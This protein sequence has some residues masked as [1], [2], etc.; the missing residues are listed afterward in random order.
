MRFSNFL[1]YIFTLLVVVVLI[2]SCQ[3]EFLCDYCGFSRIPPI[4]NAGNDTIIVIPADTAV[5]HGEKSSDADG[6]IIK[7]S[8]LQIEGPGQS[9]IANKDAATTRVK[10]L[11][12]GIYSFTLT[13]TD[14]SNL[15]SSDTVEV[16]VTDVN[17]PPVANAGPDRIAIL[18][19]D[20]LQLDGSASTD[21]ENNITTY[22]WRKLS[23]YS[24]TYIYFTERVQ[25]V[26][27][28]VSEDA[29]AFELTVTDAGGLSS[30]DTV[31]IRV[32]PA[33]FITAQMIDVGKN[34]VHRFYPTGASVGDQLIFAGGYE[35]DGFSS[36]VDIYDTRTNTHATAEL[37]VPRMYM[38][39]VTVGDKVY[40][41]GGISYNDK[42]VSRIDIY[43]SKTNTWTTDELSRARFFVSG[44]TTGNK[45]V[46]A[47][48]C[49][50]PQRE[51]CS[52]V[53]DI[54]DL[55]TKTWSVTTMTE[56]AFGTSSITYGNKVFVAGGD[57]KCGRK[58]IDVFDANSNAW[59][60]LALS[61][62]RA[63]IMSGLAGGIGY[64]GG[65]YGDSAKPKATIE[66]L[67]FITTDKSFDYMSSPVTG[68]K[69]KAIVNDNSILF[70]SGDGITRVYFNK[71][72]IGTGKSTEG[73]LD[74]NV[75][76]AEFIAHKNKIYMAGGTVDKLPN[77][78]IWTINY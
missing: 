72:E 59:S 11:K 46:F 41:A 3:K 62:P 23:G 18:P 32:T 16:L 34:I 67:N 31:V 61:E 2:A 66:I 27:Y 76:G 24:S 28:S 10:S 17:N 52:N 78:K 60:S 33:E 19:K 13:V 44:E 35:D 69:S 26:A 42:P 9:N 20:T 8:W 1:K 48:G 55:G 36:R 29:Y 39:A 77:D 30:K 75:F 64:W 12:K 54:Y 74:H 68:F 57:A 21:P 5:L 56:R 51:E 15:S 45:I 25:T 65:G 58:G 43:D 70:F 63:Y 4:A 38:A 49:T 22:K 50:N 53:A 47:G 14:N 6:S 71:Y 7:Y 40:F 73:R 37:S